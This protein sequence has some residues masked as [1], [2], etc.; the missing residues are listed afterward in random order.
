MFDHVRDWFNLSASDIISWMMT[1]T[2][3]FPIKSGR[4]DGCHRAQV[5]GCGWSLLGLILCACVVNSNLIGNQ[6][7]QK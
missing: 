6:I 3:V 7:L 1:V 2:N 5:S 4:Q